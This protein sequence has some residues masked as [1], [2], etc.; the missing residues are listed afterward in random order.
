[1]PQTVAADTYEILYTTTAY[2]QFDQTTVHGET[3][4][5]ELARQISTRQG[6]ASVHQ[7]DRLVFSYV[8]GELFT[9][10]R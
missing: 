4:A 6:H 7:G 9:D 3:D 2:N 8:D 10:N 5:H 1:M